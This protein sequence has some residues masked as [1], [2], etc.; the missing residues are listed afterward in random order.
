MKL[1]T[2]ILAL[3]PALAA[4][5]GRFGFPACTG[6]TLEL[7]DHDFFL[8]CHDSSRKVPL[9]VAYQLKPEHLIR[10]ASYRGRFSRDLQLSGPTAAGSDY[11]NSGF[12]RAHM[13]PAADF[14]WS[15]VAIRSTF[16]LSNAI[17]LLQSVNAG[18]LARIESAVRR[19]AARADVVYIFTGPIFH[20]EPELIGRG[21]AVPSHTFKV[22]LAIEGGR[23]TMYAAIVP[24]S[25]GLSKNLADFITTVDEVELRAGLDFF[26]ALD[27]AEEL[28]LEPHPRAF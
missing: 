16:V 28:P 2:L 4:Q 9:W 5:P 25:P 22:V 1:T 10:V 8:L 12:S 26:S 14:S 23:K 19:L 3:I 20:Q 17:P 6:P 13:A 15:E 21:V 18:P 11:T 24:N 27:D 7:A